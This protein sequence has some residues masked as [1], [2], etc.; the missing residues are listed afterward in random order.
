MLARKMS[1]TAEQ[2][3]LLQSDYLEEVAAQVSHQ[4]VIINTETFAILK[5]SSKDLF[6]NG[7]AI[8][9]LVT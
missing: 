8:W 6:Y 4:R 5:G 2:H 3:G 1:A 7:N 9:H